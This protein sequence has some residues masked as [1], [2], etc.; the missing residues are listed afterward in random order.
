MAKR[1]R[2]T[3]VRVRGQA[4][5]PLNSVP[6]YAT[7][8]ATVRFEPGILRPFGRPQPSLFKGALNG[9]WCCSA[10]A[11]GMCLAAWGL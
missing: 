10:A 3:G 9:S 8:K 1:S 5:A 6:T 2:A 7:C 11:A 4:H